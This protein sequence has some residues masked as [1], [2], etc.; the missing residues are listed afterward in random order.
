MTHPDARTGFMDRDPS[1]A[2][3][4]IIGGKSPANVGTLWRSAAL[5]GCQFIFTVGYR[6]PKQAS[7]TIKSWRQVPHLH[8]ATEDEFLRAAPREWELI[9]V[10]MTDQSEPLARF[11]HPRRACYLLGAEDHG[12]SPTVIR[13]CHRHL[14]LPTGCLNVAVAG[15]IVLYDWLTK[16]KKSEAA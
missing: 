14:I 8:F 13:Q 5:M 12:L 3:I 16:R 2:A 1:G 15:S 9:A 6:Y 11:T 4:G 7:D 10:E